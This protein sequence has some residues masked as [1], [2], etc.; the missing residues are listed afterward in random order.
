LSLMDN[1][2]TTGLPDSVVFPTW[3]A[4]AVGSAT[5]NPASSAAQAQYADYNSGV[6]MVTNKT[7]GV[8][9]ELIRG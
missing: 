4:G 5:I 9:C 3:P 2:P 1:Q 6:I 8:F 7:V